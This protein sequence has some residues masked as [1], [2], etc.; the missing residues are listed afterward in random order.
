[1]RAGSRPV[2]QG[3]EVRGGTVGQ[4][5]IADEGEVVIAEQGDFGDDH[6]HVSP[7]THTGHHPRGPP[8]PP[9]AQTSMCVQGVAP[10]K[11]VPQQAGGSSA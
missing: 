7:P 10:A 8:T 5:A 4:F 9:L 6:E 2:G 3:V 1:M 11:P